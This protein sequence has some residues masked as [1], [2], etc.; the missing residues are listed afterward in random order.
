[1]AADCLIDP[2]AADFDSLSVIG[3]SP[4]GYT[5]EG[6]IADGDESNALRCGCGFGCAGAPEAWFC[7]RLAREVL[8]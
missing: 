5:N 3:E 4:V 8:G 6:G 7:S 2:H 1:V